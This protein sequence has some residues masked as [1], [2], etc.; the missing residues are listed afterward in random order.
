MQSCFDAVF[1]H[2]SIYTRVAVL[3]CPQR[4]F[5]Q[6]HRSS[7]RVLPTEK[8]LSITSIVQPCR[9]IDRIHRYMHAAG[10][11]TAVSHSTFVQ[12]CL[13]RSKQLERMCDGG[14]VGAAHCVFT[15]SP[16]SERSCA[17]AFFGVGP[18][19]DGRH[20]LSRVVLGVRLELVLHKCL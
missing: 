10:H 14:V 4:S 5:S 19:V 7:N 17:F 9:S 2:C 8:L 13:Y 16:A 11:A 18:L 3:C 6:S 1:L 12:A 15:A 20:V